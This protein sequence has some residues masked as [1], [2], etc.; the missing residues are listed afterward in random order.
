MKIHYNNIHISQDWS[1]YGVDFEG[2]ASTDGD[3]ERVVVEEP[4]HLLSE[5]E[6]ALL[7]MNF[8]EPNNLNEQSMLRN[9]IVAKSFVNHHNQ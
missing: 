4:E 9:Y 2:P 8:I 6:R 5:G 3:A 7:R 1:T